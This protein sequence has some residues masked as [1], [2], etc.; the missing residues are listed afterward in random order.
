MKKTFVIALAA[1]MAGS[2][3]GMAQA[4]AV[5]RDVQVQAVKYG[6]LNL[7]READASVLLSRIESAARGVCGL[8][9]G[10]LPFGV[11]MQLERCAADATAR[12]V[13]DVNSPLLTRKG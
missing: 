5:R 4:T 2:L 3:A 10:P 8:H 11:K 1:I 13:A 9:I 6:D 7:E 12:A